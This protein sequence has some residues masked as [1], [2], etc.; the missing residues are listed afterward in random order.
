MALFDNF[1]KMIHDWIDRAIES[2]MP[3]QAVVVRSDATGVWVKFTSDKPSVPPSKFPSTVAGLP[4]GTSGWVHPL[5]GGK[6]RFIAD[7]VRVPSAPKRGMWIAGQT[8]STAGDYAFTA[9]TGLITFSGLIPGRTYELS[10]DVC[11]FWWGSAPATGSIGVRVVDNAGTSFQLAMS[12]HM[13]NGVAVYEG[14]R[15]WAFSMTITAPPSGEITICPAFRWAS[16][17]T[18]FQQATITARLD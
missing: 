8:I 1:D 6:H 5:A 15:S 17:T 13:H 7:N 10:W 12:R 4:A 14:Q 18:N 16:G 11:M 3:R 2:T 9:N